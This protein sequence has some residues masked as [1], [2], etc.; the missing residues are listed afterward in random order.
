MQSHKFAA[1]IMISV[2]LSTAF[3]FAQEREMNP[4]EKTVPADALLFIQAT[5][6][7]SIEK[8]FQETT[9]AA[10]INESEMADAARDLVRDLLRFISI[11]ATDVSYAEMKKML[12]RNIG[13]VVFEPADDRSNAPTALLFDI[14]HCAAEFREK[15][16]KR[17]KPRLQMLSRTES[18]A[19]ETIEGFTIETLSLPNGKRLSFVV[20]DD[21]LVMGDKDAISR[22]LKGAVSNPVYTNA[23]KPVFVPAG[24][25]FFLNVDAIWQGKEAE[26]TEDPTART[27]LDALGVTGIRAVAASSTFEGTGIRDRFFVSAPAPRSGIL[28]HF[29]K[30][31]AQEP[32]SVKLVPRDCSLYLTV[33]TGGGKALFDAVKNTIAQVK[34]DQALFGFEQF[35]IAIIQ[36]T[37]VDIEQDII[38]QLGNE[39]FVAADL[40][41]L[42][43]G[44][45]T[46]ENIS[47]LVGFEAPDKARL[48]GAI[49]QIIFSDYAIRNGITLDTYKYKGTDIHA[50]SLPQRP[51]LQ[52]GYTFIDGFFVL[53]PKVKAIEKLLDARDAGETLAQSENY[54]VVFGK[55]S[56]RSNLLLYI[57]IPQLLTAVAPKL[58]QSA[59]KN[60]QPLLAAVTALTEKLGGLGLTLTATEQGIVGDSYSTS[61]G[62]V[63]LLSLAWLDRLRKPRDVQ[64]IVDAHKRMARIRKAIAVYKMRTGTYPVTLD[65]LVP[66]YIKQLP[67]DP[68]GKGGA[69]FYYLS[70]SQVALAP[71]PQ[72]PTTATGYVIISVGPD[73]KLDIDPNQVTFAQLHARATSTKPG[74]IDWLKKVV[75]QYKKEIYPDEKDMF[76]E[77]DIVVFGQ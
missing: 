34:G 27:R 5:D 54:K 36:N 51:Q 39:F 22:I 52:P 64:R 35:K 61:G 42:A 31:P 56:P 6:I 10:A 1:A 12:G 57:N 13:L 48:Q 23:V 46:I 15:L 17:I 60:A 7:P 33:Q 43:A 50:I 21:V 19:P 37:G 59:P 29:C 30:Q 44:G 66:N 47:L 11:Y 69:Q 3:C 71:A 45:R 38:G 68:F 55:I 67:P 72:Q 4:I 75:Y 14:S 28:D 16:E 24:L 9:L 32:R 53:S 58:Q 2:A 63:L 77:G 8:A 40:R 74:D 20:K 73:R 25:N 18:F 49:G 41:G 70:S 76:D 62:P 65:E 26:W